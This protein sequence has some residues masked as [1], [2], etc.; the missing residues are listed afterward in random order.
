MASLAPDEQMKKYDK[1][2]VERTDFENESKTFSVLK[3]SLSLKPKNRD[4]QISELR[5]ELDNLKREMDEQ[6]ATHS[7]KMMAV[8]NEKD[9]Q[10]KVTHS[11]NV[12]FAK[13]F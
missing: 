1:L 3:S 8:L 11:R 13:N 2:L 7:K 4:S 5:K 12:L 10:I 9:K 6:L